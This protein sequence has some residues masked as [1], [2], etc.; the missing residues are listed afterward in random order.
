MASTINRCVE[1]V[2]EFQITSI[3]ASFFE[4]RTAITSRKL[5]RR[6]AIKMMRLKW[7]S[8]SCSFLHLH[9]SKFTV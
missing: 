7:T 6:D 9:F 1:S 3:R 2:P 8:L 5:S 4:T